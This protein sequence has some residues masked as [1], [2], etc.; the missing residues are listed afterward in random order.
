[1]T[2]NRF[3]PRALQWANIARDKDAAGIIAG[4]LLER[5]DIDY[6][7][8]AVPNFAHRVILGR[9]SLCDI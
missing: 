6:R 8:G 5:L 4:E 9:K 3:A 7:A 1:M 2:L